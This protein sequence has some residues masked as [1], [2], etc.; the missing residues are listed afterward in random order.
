MSGENFIID[1]RIFR[2]RLICLPIPKSGPAGTRLEFVHCEASE[3]NSPPR[4]MMGG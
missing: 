4:P 1:C 3:S 2:N